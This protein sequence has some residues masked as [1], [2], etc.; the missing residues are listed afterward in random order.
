MPTPRVM[1]DR[2]R[3]LALVAIMAAVSFIVGGVAIGLLYHA[4]FEQHRER[5]VEAV[6]G[7]A[8]MLRAVAERGR[9][10]DEILRM[11]GRALHYEP[12][13]RLI[14]I[15]LAMVA[16]GTI[17]VIMTR[18]GGALV[19]DDRSQPPVDVERLPEDVPLARAARGEAGWTV[20]VDRR[21][22]EVLAA[23]DPVDD[24]PY[25]IIARIP[26]S[27][28]RRPY[29]DA[30]LLA[31]L[32]G[33][34]VILAGAALFRRM[35]SP[36]ILKLEH[37]E[38]RHRAVIE[39]AADG[40]LT[41]DGEGR[42]RSI[43]RAAEA[44]F[45]VTA[46]EAIGAPVR[47][48]LPL[49]EGTLVAWGDGADEDG[50]AVH[51]KFH[52]RRRDGRAVIV[53]VGVTLGQVGDHE[54]TTLVVHDVT[55]Q[56]QAAEALRRT[57]QELELKNAELAEARDAALEATRL[58]SEFLATMSHEIRTPLNGV[59]GMTSLL[60]ETPL[61]DEQSEYAEVARQSGE[62]LLALVNDILDLSRLEARRVELETMPFSPAALVRQLCE[63]FEEPAARKGLSL[64][65]EATPNVPERVIGDPARLRQILSNLIDNAVKFTPEGH[66][67]VRVTLGTLPGDG[68]APLR[69][70]VEDTGIG[71]SADQAAHLFEPFIQGDP[72]TTRRYGGS[73]LGLAISQHL[74]ELMDGKLGVTSVS[75]QGATFWL[76]VNLPLPDQPAPDLAH[77]EAPAAPKAP[78]P[79][80]NGRRGRVL[81][82]E[83]NEV[84][85][86]VALRILE[87]LGCDADLAANGHEALRKLEERGYDL[88]LMDCQMPEMDGYEASEHIRRREAQRRNG[89]VPIVAMTA[90]ALKGDRERC[91]AAGMDDYVAKPLKTGD[92]A[93]LL[94]RWLHA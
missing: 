55:E 49:P 65:W 87:R 25:V 52:T 86:K 58:K 33:V 16:N 4:A 14:D 19:T 45:G 15:E 80:A 28:L 35:T 42:I 70:E 11:L 48:L 23:Y 83:D 51:H 59:I 9:T 69:F 37:S 17:R 7:Q 43:N 34:G 94:D 71:V 32:A 44:I 60:L 13:G 31:A 29:L 3:V 54:M 68:R 40:I 62:V 46:A 20:G 77:S 30:A 91:I 72:S 64:R 67:V 81:V 10:H 79:H 88:V 1:S 6:T 82:A 85:Q 53:D 74:A 26:V 27:E 36:L 41:A 76:R 84:N 92:V 24:T 63:L 50:H 57:A 66:V 90:N 39:L 2:R 12:V 47:E 89:H 8:Q 75:G 61:T 56:E 5:L 78:P 38:A 21:G 93:A 73:G 22:E 18:T